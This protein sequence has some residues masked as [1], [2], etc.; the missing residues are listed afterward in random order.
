MRA[1]FY[2]FHHKPLKEQ[3]VEELVNEKDDGACVNRVAR[4]EGVDETA[5]DSDQERNNQV[6]KEEEQRQ[7]AEQGASQGRGWSR[8]S[9]VADQL[10]SGL[11][12]RDH[13]R[14]GRKP[15]KVCAEVIGSGQS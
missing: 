9:E 11:E 3:S 14:Q 15:G 8:S 6:R 5:I 10:Y 4:R 12:P 7:I 1:P 2:G 13:N